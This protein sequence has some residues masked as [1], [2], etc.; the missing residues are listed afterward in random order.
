MICL[1]FAVP[2]IARRII[3]I[4]GLASLG[5][6]TGSAL[7][8]SYWVWHRNTAFD[9]S[10]LQSLKQAGVKEIYWQVGTLVPKEADWSWQ[11]RF[12]VDFKALKKAA[13]FLHIIPV[14]RLEPKN[15]QSPTAENLA[16]LGP[17]LDDVVSDS[18]A[19]WLQIDY[20]PPDRLI[21][22][23]EDFLRS[24]K[25]KHVSWK[26]SISALAHWSKFANEFQ[27]LVDEITPMFYD[28]NP[29]RESL[30]GGLLPPLIDAATAEKEMVSWK[31]CKLPWKAGLPNFCRVT[32]LNDKGVSRGNVR[33]WNLDEFWFSPALTPDFPTVQEQSV[34]SVNQS[35]VL[36]G[37]LLQPKERVVVRYPELG[38]LIELRSAA[39]A[40]GA[41]GVLF[42]RLSDR[43]D[44]SGYSVATLSQN[45]ITEPT[46]SVHRN[47]SSGIILRNDSTQ[48]LLPRIS[49]NGVRGYA[50]E[51]K[52]EPGSWREA[53]AGDFSL[54]ST[55]T[56]GKKPVIDQIGLE[57]STISFWFSSLRAGQTLE[58]GLVQNLSDHPLNWR[59]SILKQTP[60]WQPLD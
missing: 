11:E 2:R 35:C 15:G 29:E 45:K 25:Q 9:S 41:D 52:S 20:E 24:I 3:I 36:L 48:D 49:E 42:F 40:S 7:D 47:A 27:G 39:E 43:L 34:F 51:L 58:T 37:T 26:V 50:L 1:K 4:L 60:A 55:D 17:I 6:A 44:M 32:I 13:P 46:L 54:V 38:T 5:I 18:A 14:I 19:D 53:V 23:Y 10:E 22:Q 30:T 28:L 56:E 33:R 31:S 57:V 16:R 12:P 21:P 8:S 59:L